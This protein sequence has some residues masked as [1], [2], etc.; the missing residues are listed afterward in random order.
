MVFLEHL[1]MTRPDIHPY[2]A[3]VQGS[4][5]RSHFGSPR[6]ALL[7]ALRCG[8]GRYFYDWNY[9]PARCLAAEAMQ[10]G[11]VTAFLEVLRA[12]LD[13]R[14]LVRRTRR[15]PRRQLSGW[16]AWDLVTGALRSAFPEDVTAFDRRIGRV[17]LHIADGPAPWSATALDRGRGATPLIR[18]AFSGSASDIL[19]LTRSVGASLVLANPHRIA[20]ASDD[21]TLSGAI[22]R[23]L[24]M[25][26][27]ARTEPA[28]LAGLQRAAGAESRAT[29]SMLGAGEARDQV[30]LPFPSRMS[31]EAIESLADELVD[32]LPRSDLWS[33]LSGDV[34]GLLFRS[35][36]DTRRRPHAAASFEPAEM[37]RRSPIAVR[38]GLAA[39]QWLQLGGA[40]STPGDFSARHGQAPTQPKTDGPPAGTVVEALG[41]AILA[42][43]RSDYHRGFDLRRYLRRHIL[44]PLARGGMRTW[45]DADGSVAGFVTWGL[46]SPVVEAELHR[47]G[48]ALGGR[49]WASGD[50]VFI[51]DLVT[52]P[53]AFREIFTELKA[54]LFRNADVSSLRRNPDGS[55]RRVNRWRGDGLRKRPGRTLRHQPSSSRP[56]ISRVAIGS[57]GSCRPDMR[58]LA[59]ACDAVIQ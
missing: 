7:R 9:A 51:N 45:F 21:V 15:T 59:Y 48:R 8:N 29:A 57:G 11:S 41:A 55:V 53:D 24:L 18:C 39:I 42:L 52:A 12:E 44:P 13:L 6:S 14:E 32:A 54:D 33:V 4:E 5:A 22:A 40:A 47:T 20:L 1:R 50:R 23:R 58:A 17:G 25:D 10:S 35:Q 36:S 30:A 56:R 16:D 49:D 27:V 34:S 26:Q 43:A 31:A 46:V 37:G 2:I 38:V 28:L 3:A 19:D